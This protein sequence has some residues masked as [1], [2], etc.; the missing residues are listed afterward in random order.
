MGP[1]V[2]SHYTAATSSSNSHPA[3]TLPYRA[4]EIR[5]YYWFTVV[6]SLMPDG[7]A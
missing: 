2:F 4:R 6:S 3:I 5:F 1:L 7:M